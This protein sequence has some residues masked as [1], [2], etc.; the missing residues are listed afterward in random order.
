MVNL[1]LYNVI[2]DVEASVGAWS[3]EVKDQIAIWL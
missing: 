2:D 1:L 3:E